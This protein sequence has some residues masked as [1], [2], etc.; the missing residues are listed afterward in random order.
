MCC[1]TFA[2]REV[3]Q[4]WSIAPVLKTG[5]PQGTGG[6]NPSASAKETDRDVGF[7]CARHFPSA[8]RCIFASHVVPFIFTLDGC[9]GLCLRRHVERTALRSPAELAMRRAQPK[10]ARWPGVFGHSD[11]MDVQRARSKR[12]LDPYRDCVFPRRCVGFRQKQH[13]DP[14]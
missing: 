7:F 3:W 4:S 1:A 14:S 8:L 13:L 6:S 2:V 9:L 12:Q 10:D 11:V 5:V